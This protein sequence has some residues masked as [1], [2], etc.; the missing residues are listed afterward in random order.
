[1]NYKKL[2]RTRVI[3]SLLFFVLT[4]SLFLDIYEKYANETVQEI[5]FLQFIP[6]LMKF[7]SSFA[8]GAI[9]FLIIIAITVFM[10]RFYC[11]AICPLGILQDVFAWIAKKRS[12]KKFFYKKKKSHPILRY[13][14]LGISVIGLLF[15]FSTIIT[16]L[17][18]Y[19]NFGRIMTYLFRPIVV[20]AN[21]GVSTLL[22]QFEVYSINPIKLE[23]SP[24]VIF[25]FTLLV[26]IGIAYYSYKRGRLFC[27]TICPVGTFLGLLSKVSFL[28]IQFNEDN[29]TKC[30]KC[31]GECKSECIDLKNFTVDHSR[32]VDC[33]NCVS[34]CEDN[35]LKFASKQRTVAPEQTASRR[36][37][38]V[39]GLTLLFGA[40]VMAETNIKKDTSKLL[41]NKKDHP[42]SPPGS[43]SINRFNDV[44][45]G[46]GLCV[47]A[48]PTQVL[49]P[50]IGQYGIKGFM[51]PH[52][53]YLSGYC[54][55]DCRGCGQVCPTSAILPISIE[56]K[57]ITQ[58]GKAVFV[59]ENCVVYTDGTDCG[60]CSEHC[61][62]KAVDMIPYE[63]N[64]LIPEV[65]Q[66][67]CIG[68]GACEHPCPV[69]APFKAIYVNGNAVHQAA[70]KPKEEAQTTA[71]VEEDFPF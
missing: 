15:S 64:L 48:C 70:D 2:K 33:F 52:M 66:S 37:A 36:T 67:I 49:Q 14:L 26:F 62:T 16:I 38:I 21:N 40:K 54:N 34:V 19:S 12:T 7:I 56:E 46:C 13:T 10:G 51:Q 8:I 28:K 1:M 20:I 9:G 5:L 68:C 50:A 27:N 71:P 59:K 69:D 25:T 45:T 11:S 6:S 3:I 17:D 29:C 53:D 65:N 4:A 57:Q 60:A 35:A 31:I 41:E 18:P 43:I 55:F 22:H 61:P 30:G 63:G 42:V 58:L 24:M 23:M 47:A 32:C 39:S 44:C